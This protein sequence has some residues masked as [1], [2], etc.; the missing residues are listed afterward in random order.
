MGTSAQGAK[1]KTQNRGARPPAHKKTR[2][3]SPC[4]PVPL[5]IGAPAL[6]GRKETRPTTAARARAVCF[7]PISYHRIKEILNAAINGEPLPDA[8]V[9][10]TQ[11]S[12]TF[13]RSSAEIFPHTPVVQP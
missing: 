1:R 6:Q 13:A 12:L 5:A 4:P 8:P 10:G 9:T 3:G 11:Q 2:G 7:G